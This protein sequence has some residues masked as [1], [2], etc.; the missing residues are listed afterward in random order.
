MKEQY[1]SIIYI[2]LEVNECRKIR[3]GAISETL[4]GNN[5]R[6]GTKRVNRICKV[7]AR[8]LRSQKIALVVSHYGNRISKDKSNCDCHDS[9]LRLE[10]MIV[11]T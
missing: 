5:Q 4:A 8:G 11:T 9:C 1:D 3:R 6:N 10:N 7:H 2:R